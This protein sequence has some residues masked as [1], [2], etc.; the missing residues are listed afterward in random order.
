MGKNDSEKRLSRCTVLRERIF[1]S[2]IGVKRIIKFMGLKSEVSFES[3]GDKNLNIFK[4]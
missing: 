1:D 2:N 4:A 3:S